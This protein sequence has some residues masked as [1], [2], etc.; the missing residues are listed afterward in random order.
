MSCDPHKLDYELML[1]YIYIYKTC[2]NIYLLEINIKNM[3]ENDSNVKT[4]I[5]CN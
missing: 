5:T 2:F 1:H 3:F 4:H